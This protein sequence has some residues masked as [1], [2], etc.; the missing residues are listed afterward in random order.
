MTG[1][2]FL[3]VILP[4]EFYLIQQKEIL[5]F[6]S[7]SRPVLGGE[8]ILTLVSGGKGKVPTDS[9]KLAGFFVAV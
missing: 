2:N 9:I 4:I 3:G 1:D 7:K 6:C 5:Q 8:L